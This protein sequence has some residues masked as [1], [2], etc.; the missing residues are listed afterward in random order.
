MALFI[1]PPQWPA[2]GTLFSHLVSD[3]SIQELRDF[4][5]AQE[6]PER[7]FDR[8]HYDVPQSRYETLVAAGAQPVAATELVRRLVRSGLRVPARER[9]ERLDAVLLARWDALLPGHGELGRELLARWSEPHRK[10]HDRAH[11]LAVL[12]A[13]DVLIGST[14]REAMHHRPV[15]LAAWFHDAVYKGSASD[16]LDSAA[17]ATAM[18][19]AAGLDSGE[20]GDVV[21]LVGLTVEHR[22]GS[23]DLQGQ[24]LCDAD[25][26]VLGR[27]AAAYRRYAAAVREEYAHVADAAFAQGRS[28]ILRKLLA[29]DFLYSGAQARAL[30]EAPARENLER[31]L[32]DLAFLADPRNR[33]S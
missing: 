4:A 1:D 6:L 10:Y 14:E 30:W 8:D 20:I 17:L 33:P 7:A 11:L 29:A 32:A 2:H 13:L 25:L 3:V 15:Y 31:E 26:E 27:P 21:R 5:D 9:P 23:E 12:K 18:L 28:A 22:P 16:E 24:M 19:P